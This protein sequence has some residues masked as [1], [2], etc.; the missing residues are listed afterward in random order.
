MT[1]MITLA[2]QTD[3]RFVDIFTCSACAKQE[4]IV[5]VD[6]QEG[7]GGNTT[8]D[9]KAA[10]IFLSIQKSFLEESCDG[11]YQTLQQ[12]YASKAILRLYLHFRDCL[13]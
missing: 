1:E 8:T 12:P 2:R 10:E 3:D 6:V 4:T 5:V 13:R 9:G 7:Q 11:I